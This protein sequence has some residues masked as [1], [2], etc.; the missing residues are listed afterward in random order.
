M[1]HFT[2]ENVT[3]LINGKIEKVKI[4]ISLEGVYSALDHSIITVNNVRN[5]NLELKYNDFLATPV[6]DVDNMFLMHDED[7]NLYKIGFNRDPMSVLRDAKN[8]RYRSILACCDLYQALEVVQ[9]MSNFTKRQNKDGWFVCNKE[10]ITTLISLMRK[11][12]YHSGHQDNQNKKSET[13][14]TES[15]PCSEDEVKV[16]TSDTLTSSIEAYKST[17][18]YWNP[19][20]GT[21]LSTH[22]DTRQCFTGPTSPY[23]KITTLLCSEQKDK[24]W[25]KD[26]QFALFDGAVIGRHGVHSQCVSIWNTHSDISAGMNNTIMISTNTNIRDMLVTP[27]GILIYEKGSCVLRLL[28]PLG[29]AM[30]YS[31]P[32]CDST[33]ELIKYDPNYQHTC[34]DPSK[35][36]ISDVCEEYEFKEHNSMSKGAFVTLDTEDRIMLLDPNISGC[37]SSTTYEKRIYDFDIFSNSNIITARRSSILI[38]DRKT[39][40]RKLYFDGGDKIWDFKKI[41][42]LDD[43]HVLLY[44][45]DD[46]VHVWSDN[47]LGRQE[48]IT[49][50]V[51]CLPFLCST[52]HNHIVVR[53]R[54]ETVVMSWGKNHNLVMWSLHFKQKIHIFPEMM[55]S[56]C[57]K[58]LPYKNNCV[59]V[60]DEKTLKVIDINI[61][62]Q[63]G[64]DFSTAVTNIY[65]DDYCIIDFAVISDNKIMIYSDSPQEK[66][67]I[68]SQV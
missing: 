7:L 37:Y 67:K 27:A 60:A 40:A 44:E 68:L 17:F 52:L 16:H 32:S 13:Y 28:G 56:R 6:P 23:S 12:R 5:C 11:A 31:T 2:M 54:D 36:S 38:H 63:P 65:S 20:S 66:V 48:T 22:S 39:R 30:R 21:L 25:D 14:N 50:S 8:D 19:H 46:G 45:T 53:V 61:S 59:L 55:C 26:W 10:E 43:E 42:V 64:V 3:L 51:T 49:P 4:R 9:Y 57:H 18:F 1:S 47:F 58:I 33:F 34:S 62:L 15:E 35:Y 24:N 29:G 41:I